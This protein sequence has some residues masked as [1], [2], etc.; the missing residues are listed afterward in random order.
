MGKKLLIVAPVPLRE[1]QGRL[2]LDTQTCDA[3]V[4]WSENFDEVVLACPL[5]PQT[6]RA[7]SINASLE[8]WQALADLPCADR[9]E[10]VP[11]PYAYQLQVFLQTYRE[12]ARL[13]RQ[14]ILECQYL[15]F[16]VGGL[17]GD[18][19]AIACLE[20]M[21]LQRPY[22]VSFGRVE[23]EVL[24]QMAPYESWK[25]RLKYLFTLPLMKQYHRYLVRH[26]SL[27][28][29]QGQ[30]CYDEFASFCPQPHC[31]YN[32]NTQKTDQIKAAELQAKTQEVLSGA[33]LSICYV[34]RAAEMKGPF[35]WIRAIHQATQKGVNLKATWIGQGPLLEEMRSLI[36]SLGLTDRI[37]LLGFISDRSQLLQ[38]LRQQHIFLFCHQ[39]PEAPRCLIEALIS[40]CPLIGYGSPYAKALVD[41]EGG[42]SFVP[43]QDWQG[44]A[45]LLQTFD[46]D[47]EQL[48][49]LIAAA[50]R[51]GQP[52]DQETV[53]RHRSELIQQYLS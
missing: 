48:A 33:P 40:G 16:G 17:V 1:H 19:P 39:T 29:F 50:A 45:N 35:D 34:G 31:V 14:K 37:Q 5:L 2:E 52:F 4:R 26:A 53:Y 28:L 23:Y 24:H 6:I 51:S 42:G 9:L 47:R 22:S 44:L 21:R 15:C 27:G 25:R 18:W 11:L 41:Q 10:V 49:Q 12:T 32:T 7:E 3:L 46:R 13:L 20:A 38:R 30:D 36:Q 43:V 8:S